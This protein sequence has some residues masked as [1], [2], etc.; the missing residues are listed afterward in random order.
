METTAAT[1]HQP[2]EG[3]FRHILICLDRSEAAERVLPLA[4][5]L[6]NSDCAQITLLHVLESRSSATTGR[7]TDAIGWEIARTEARA[8]LESVGDRVAPATQTHVT[9]G[10]TARR[11]VTMAEEFHA[12]LIAIT[13]HGEGG[14]AG[15]DLG[16]TTEKVLALTA[17][18]VLIV[19]TDPSGIA[20]RIPPRRILIPL[21]GSRRTESVLP[22]AVRFA[23]RAEAEIV[24]AHV[25]WEPIRTEILSS[26][27]DLGLARKLAERQASNAARYLERMRERLASDGVAAR[28]VVRRGRDH[29]EALVSLATAEQADLVVLCAH[30]SVCN[31][32]RPFGSMTKYLITHASVPLLVIQDIADRVRISS[33]PPP[34]PAPRTPLPPRSVDELGRG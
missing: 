25:V 13:T 12:D 34:P 17:G 20:A 2:H 10:S 31:A 33:L 30:G 7:A 18:S 24:L 3:A 8:Y 16:S 4:A 6:A 27:E 22:I 23:R 14:A 1:S 9:E 19:P 28:V 32:R 29:R 5:Y 26:A 11:I 15:W 21:D